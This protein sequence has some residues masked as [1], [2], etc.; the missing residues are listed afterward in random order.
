[1]PKS[2][3][4]RE[5]LKRSAA[6]GG[7]AA[8]SPLLANFPNIALPKSRQEPITLE[9]WNT[10]SDAEIALLH[11]MGDEY[12]AENP[13]VKVNFYEI[14]FD[15]RATAVPTAV[16]TD[17]LPDILRA[18]FPYQ[19]YLAAVGKA[20]ALDDLTAGWEM[21]EAIFPGIWDSV[22]YEG[23]ILA[24]PQD[25]FTSVLCYNVDKFKKDGVES[26]PATW[27]EL[28]EACLKL[29]HDD[30][31]ALALKFGGGIDWELVPLIFGA[32]GKPWDENGA[33]M[34]NDAKGVAALQYAL[35][36]ANVHKVMP[37]GVANFAYGET[38]DAVKSGK[39]GMGAFGSWQIAN[40]RAAQVPFELGIG[41]WPAGP[42]GSR[43]TWAGTGFYVVMNTSPYPEE[44]V[45][46]LQWIVSKD[47]AK[48]W[49]ME[50][51]HEPIDSFTAAD[52]YFQ[53]PIFQAFA[54]SVPFTNNQP[55]VPRYNSVSRAM[56][57]NA[58]KALLGE[59]TA[60]Q[61]MN[62]IADEMTKAIS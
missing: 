50:L 47:N 16:E 9:F 34:M 44:A 53:K 22:T 29:T 10:F 33:P 1:M 54:E 32:G 25:R 6:L 18:D 30:E 60:E 43:G 24:I 51:D 23:Q 46:L 12:M 38:D 26:F 48:R 13:N 39:L 15:Q 62:A 57:E 58:Q 61:A 55:P 40:Y 36:L 7:L 11:K 4:R 45:K 59:M 41:A 21:R 49:A 2:I 3:S 37:P 56:D 28:T 27:D 42:D 5:F 17:T 52:E 8:A 19:Y 35:D 31:Y 14:P 20:L